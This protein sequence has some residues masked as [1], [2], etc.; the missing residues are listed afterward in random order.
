[1]K[2]RLGTSQRMRNHEFPQVLA[3]G[4]ALDLLTSNNAGCTEPVAGFVSRILANNARDLKQERLL[5]G[6][7]VWFQ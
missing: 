6:G 3:V 5:K 1:M 7:G 4:K 2:N